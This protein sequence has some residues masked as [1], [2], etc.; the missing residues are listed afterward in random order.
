MTAFQQQSFDFGESKP[1][2]LF[3]LLML[4]ET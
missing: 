1:S 3:V 4:Y 2:S